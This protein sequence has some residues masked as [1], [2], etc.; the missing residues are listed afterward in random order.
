MRKY[1][2]RKWNPKQ[3]KNSCTHISQ[4]RLQNKISQ[5]D[6]EGFF[7]LIKGAIH[8]EEIAIVN[9]YTSNASAPN[10]IK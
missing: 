5:E 4:G 2:L 7:I 10:F 3:S 8:Q 6:K 1:F 9:I